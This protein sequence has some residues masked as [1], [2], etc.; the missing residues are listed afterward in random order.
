MSAR[1]STKS[2]RSRR[3]D[4][5]LTAGML[6]VALAG[7]RSA[8]FRDSGH[9]ATAPRGVPAQLVSA[10]N[11]SLSTKKPEASTKKPEAWQLQK[12]QREDAVRQVA[13]E[14]KSKDSATT[15]SFESELW[16]SDQ[17]APL[18]SNETSW[19]SECPLSECPAECECPGLCLGCDIENALPTL[20]CDAKGVLAGN[21]WMILAGAGGVAIWFREGDIDREVREKVADNPHRWGDGSQFL[22]KIGDVRYQ[23]PVLLGMYGYSLWSQ[24]E[25]LHDVSGSLLSA[26]VITGIST[27]ALK[28]VTNTERP[29]DD[30]MDGEYGFPSYHTASTFAIAA[31]LEEY[32]GY[33]VGLPAYLL[34]GAVGFSRLDEQ[35]HDL[36]DV[37]FGGA[38]GFVIGK[39]VAGRHRCGN[40]KI[41]F[42]PYFHPTDGS[43]GIGGE[44]KF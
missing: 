22:G 41:Q 9:S 16:K 14:S 40:S 21:N 31:V 43:P 24:N 1:G 12:S 36:S 11:S 27:S 29:S 8:A 26:S 2:T 42:T 13:A 44:M 37:V 34:A 3:L 4:L 28:L 15:A 17:P 32:Y 38:L 6:C 7:C 5:W 23:A 30:W 18:V 25:E 10:T 35:D 39:A 19:C 33:K 20:W